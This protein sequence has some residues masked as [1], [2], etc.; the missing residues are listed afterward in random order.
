MNYASILTFKLIVVTYVII[1]RPNPHDRKEASKFY[2]TAKS[3]GDLTFRQLSKETTE[4]LTAVS[5]TNVLSVLNNL[6]K[7][8]T[9]HLENGEIVRI[10]DWFVPTSHS[11]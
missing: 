9:R 10:G 6:T 11:K 4:G 8:L 3:L 7:V 5:D 1:P 2:S